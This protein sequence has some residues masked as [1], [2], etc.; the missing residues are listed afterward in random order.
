MF[1]K[2]SSQALQT[3][4]KFSHQEPRNSVTQLGCRECPLLPKGNLLRFK[5]QEIEAWV[6][7]D[8]PGWG[9]HYH[10]SVRMEILKNHLIQC[11]FIGDN[12]EVHITKESGGKTV[13][14]LLI[15]VL[16]FYFTILRIFTFSVFRTWSIQTF[17]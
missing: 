14:V 6:G 13:K 11:F 2:W 8:L 16:L 10:S 5:I 4:V 9:K 3:F 7:Q 1:K 12:T 15:P 17:K